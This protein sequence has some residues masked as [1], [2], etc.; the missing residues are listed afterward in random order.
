M[1]GLKNALLLFCKP[2]IPG[3]VKTRLTE[4]RGGALSDTEAA[5][6]FRCS[7][8]DITELS[9]LALDDLNYLNKSARADCTDGSFEH[10]KEYDFFVSSISDQ[11]IL[12]LR[13][14][15]E[16]DGPWS[17]EINYLLD[18]GA[19]FDEHFDNAFD[20]LF[21]KGYDTVVAIGGDM[22]LLPR[23]H[24]VDAFLWLD[25]LAA[26]N[27]YGYAFVQA[28]C[29]QSG[30]SIVGKTR[31]T[32]MT[33]SG[34]YYNLS[35][36]PALDAYT[37]KLRELDIPNAFLHPVSDVDGDE[38][39]AHA[40]SCLNAIAEAIPYQPDIFLARRVLEW[41]DKLGL[42]VKAPPNEAHDPRQFID[43]N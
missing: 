29:Q 39:L 42:Q 6:F 22:P 41:V 25:H 14:M 12:E 40:I 43:T 32:P 13:E 30:V 24:L 28:P 11:A 20:Q 23:T 34:I 33:A 3:L 38:D 4:K 7:L 17:H 27:E 5:E 15:Y 19:S 1:T 31:T 21:E 16:C 37:D 9:M 18:R 10:I 35:G 26:Q 8:L 36:L 2:P